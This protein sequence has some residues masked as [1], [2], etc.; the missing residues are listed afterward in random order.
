MGSAALY[1]LARRGCDVL[2][3][4]PLRPGEARGSSHGSCRIFRRAVFKFPERGLYTVLSDR[5]FAGWRALE[6]LDP[7]RKPF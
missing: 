3:F 7:P 2:G 5:A 1:E 4:D 6:S